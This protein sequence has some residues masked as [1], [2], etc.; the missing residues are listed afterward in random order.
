[1]SIEPMRQ[2]TSLYE[3]ISKA[4]EPIFLTQDEYDFL[5][6]AINEW[7]DQEELINP[8]IDYDVDPSELLDR[9]EDIVL[10]EEED[11]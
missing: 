8:S 6:M 11:S 1:M 10:T 2:S 3:K 4:L 7:Q 9:L 5:E